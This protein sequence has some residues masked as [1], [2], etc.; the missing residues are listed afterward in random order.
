MCQLRSYGIQCRRITAKVVL[1]DR[2]CSARCC[3]RMVVGRA[4]RGRSSPDKGD[5][6]AP[7]GARNALF[8]RKFPE[9]TFTPEYLI[10]KG[11]SRNTCLGQAVTRARRAWR[12]SGVA[13]AS[14]DGAHRSGMVC[15]ASAG[16][17]AKASL[18]SRAHL[19]LVARLRIAQRCS[20]ASRATIPLCRA[21]RPRRAPQHPQLTAHSL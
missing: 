3:M 8:P 6:L 7:R 20:P 13:T 16:P 4:A 11:I 18:P 19:A 12:W 2:W 9:T 15:G 10:S 14:G 5:F 17:R 21:R 1:C